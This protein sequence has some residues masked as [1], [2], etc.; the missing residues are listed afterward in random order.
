M[1]SCKKEWLIGQRGFTIIEILVVVIIIS[2]IAAIAVPLL[3]RSRASATETSA[4]GALKIIAGGQNEY[5]NNAMPH[6]FSA[7]LQNLYTGKGAG[8]VGFVDESIGRGVKG[9]YTF[10]IIPGT[11]KEPGIF[12]SWRATCWPIVYRSTGIRSFHIDE[13]GVIRGADNGGT[14]GDPLMPSIE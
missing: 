8:N 6:T 2:I 5:F 10:M 7:N 1:S 3:M 9:G 11:E 12:T 14:P 4:M 13:T